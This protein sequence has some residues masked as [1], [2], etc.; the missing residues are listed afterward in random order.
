MHMVWKKFAVLN[1]EL[2]AEI[3]VAYLLHLTPM[4]PGRKHFSFSHFSVHSNNIVHFSHF[5]LKVSKLPGT[6]EPV[7]SNV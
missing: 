4:L 3:Q 6:I 1:N 5:F 7:C 2:Q